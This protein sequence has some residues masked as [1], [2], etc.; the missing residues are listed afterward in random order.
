M[1]LEGK[2]AIVTG[3]AIRIGRSIAL[4]LA[5]HGVKIALHFGHSRSEAEETA[6]EIRTLGI[7]VCLIQAD[8]QHPV[9]AA[10]AIVG[11]AISHF[12][13]VDILVN[14]AAIFE[15]GSLAS[16]TEDQFD[17]HFNVN[18]K[19]PL[20]LSRQF[21][22]ALLPEKRGHIVNIADW[23][24]TNPAPGHL[25]YTLTKHSLLALSTILA[26]ELAPR[27]QVN[28]VCPG[29]VLAP[30]GAGPADIQNVLREIPLARF[31]TADEISRAVVFLLQSDFATGTV[32]HVDG[33]QRF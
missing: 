17:R 2:V 14:S 32:L 20:F 22:Q 8:L 5:G 6:A 12:E 21:A 24:G 29:A 30:V 3:A 25:A 31:G 13:Q 4:N 33:G 26:R 27:I 1:D 11:R 15:T 16:T 19:A 18:T 9:A 7:D 10:E 23:R 28:S